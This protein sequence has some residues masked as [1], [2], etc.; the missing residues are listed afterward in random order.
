[1]ADDLITLANKPLEYQNVSPVV[2]QQMAQIAANTEA[3]P[4][5]YGKGIA[6]ESGF[7]T[8]DAATRQGGA[9][10][11]QDQ[12]GSVI[13][14]IGLRNTRRA[15]DFVDNMQRGI[16]LNAPVIKSAGYAQQAG[17]VANMGQIALNNYKIMKQQQMN[18]TRV[19]MFEQQQQQSLIAGILGIIGSV[20]GA[21]IGAA[22]GG[23]AGAV[24]GSAIGGRI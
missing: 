23:P 14:A 1:M 15:N 6:T 18:Q 17:N 20:G 7:L 12:T 16:A 11:G 9:L 22:V 3:M 24:A 13:G 10:G 2:K 21:V 4:A 5:N 8:P 19:Q